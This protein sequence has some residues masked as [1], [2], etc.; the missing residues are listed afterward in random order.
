LLGLD[1]ARIERIIDS[2]SDPMSCVPAVKFTGGEV[3]A[4]QRVTQVDG[5]MH[6][7]ICPK[8]ISSQ[9]SFLSEA[10]VHDFTQLAWQILGRMGQRRKNH[11]PMSAM[12]PS[13]FV[14]GHVYRIESKG[15]RLQVFAEKRG[16]I[17]VVDDQDIYFSHITA[18]D[19]QIFRTVN[20]RVDQHVQDAKKHNSSY[21]YVLE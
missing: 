5:R 20:F 12:E 8:A 9:S 4:W 3:N 19:F 14:Q 16:V 10:Q 13:Y 15:Q 7:E 18:S 17:L 2:V 11:L 1:Q 21:A 6:R